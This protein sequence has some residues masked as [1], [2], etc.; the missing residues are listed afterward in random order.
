MSRKL[1]IL[2]NRRFMRKLSSFKLFIQ[3]YVCLELSSKF[4]SLQQYLLVVSIFI[5]SLAYVSGL[6]LH[7]LFNHNFTFPYCSKI[8]VRVSYIS[9]YDCFVHVFCVHTT[10]FGVFRLLKLLVISTITKLYAFNIANCS[11]HMSFSLIHR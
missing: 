1:S 11:C 8:K 2:Y 5:A 3:W 6:A 7:L 4:R 9:S 10:K